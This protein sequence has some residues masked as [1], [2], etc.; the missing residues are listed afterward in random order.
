[1]QQE[2]IAKAYQLNVTDISAIAPTVSQIRR[3]V[4]EVDILVCSAGT[5]IRKLAEEVTE[6]DWDTI[7]SIN[8][9]GLFFAIR[10]WQSSQ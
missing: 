1:V 7:L 6:A 2:G 5:N 10:Q 4:G 8:T 9:K 3:D